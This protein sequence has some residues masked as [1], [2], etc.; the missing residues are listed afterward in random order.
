MSLAYPLP[1]STRQAPDM[2]GDGVTLAFPF[3]FRLMDETD[4]AVFVQPPGGTDF[5]LATLGAQY[6]VSGL[7]DAAG[8]T[9]DFLAAPAAGAI[10]RL[11]R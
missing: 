1:K 4:I 9:V 3:A 11:R 2:L 10:V 6:N 7:G 5:A 8:G